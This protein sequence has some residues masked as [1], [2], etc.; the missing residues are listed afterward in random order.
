M[1]DK[2]IPKSII[3]T[4]K[5][6]LTAEWNDGYKSTIKLSSLRKECP[7]A[8]CQTDKLNRKEKTFMSLDT[9]TPGK[10]ELKKLEQVGNY[11]VQV[12]WADGHDTGIY[13]WELLRQ[14]FEKYKI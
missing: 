6:K 12:Q 13:T 3:R 5:D 10:N 14:I 2:F 4:E 8:Q 9:F 7:C 11:A 1:T